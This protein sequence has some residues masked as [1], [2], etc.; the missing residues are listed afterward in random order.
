MA[1]SWSQGS[2][3]RVQ[4]TAITDLLL[5]MCLDFLPGDTEG[6]REA[7]GVVARSQ[8]HVQLHSGQDAA[9]DLEARK[10]SAIPQLQIFIATIIS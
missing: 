4:V 2:Q 9:S 8:S 10:H 3:T 7:E 5:L 6:R 1:W